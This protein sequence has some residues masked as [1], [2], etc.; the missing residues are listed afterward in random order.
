MP[1]L[2]GASVLVAG[3]GLAGLSAAHDLVERGAQVAIVDARDRVGGRVCTV[4]A[5]FADQQHAEAGGDMIDE[6]QHEIRAL[7]KDYKLSLTRILRGGFTYARPDQKGRV[8]LMNQSSIRGWDR[9][10]EAL[11]DTIRPYRLAERRWDTPIASAI[12]RRSVAAWLDEI[13]ADDELRMTAT[14]LRGFFLA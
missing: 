6:G 3:A 7:A 13:K 9:L 10:A 11:A 4:R 5:P 2:S 12:A 8:R 14:G 1:S